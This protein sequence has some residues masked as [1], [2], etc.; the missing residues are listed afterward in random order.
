MRVHQLEL[1]RSG[2]NGTMTPNSM[3]ESPSRASVAST[4]GIPSTVVSSPYHILDPRSLSALMHNPQFAANFGLG[5]DSHATAV[6]NALE[7]RTALEQRNAL[8]Q[9]FLGIFSSKNRFSDLFFAC[10][11]H[12]SY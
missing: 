6:M 2:A 8:E 10:Y 5:M 4:H 11:S 1:I 7:Q 9:R 12:P 3:R